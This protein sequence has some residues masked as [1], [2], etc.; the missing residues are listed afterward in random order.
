MKL[1]TL[2]IG[3]RLESLCSITSRA[4][5]SK[6]N[7]LSFEG[8]L[9]S[10]ISL[11][12]LWEIPCPISFSVAKL[13]LQSFKNCLIGGLYLSVCL[14]MTRR[15]VVVSYVELNTPISKRVAVELLPVVRDECIWYTITA[16]DILPKEPFDAF[17]RNI[18][19]GLYFCPF[20][21]IIDNHDCKSN[22][23][24]FLGVKVPLYL[25][26]IVRRAKVKKSINFFLLLIV[27]PPI[28]SKP[29]LSL[30]HSTISLVVEK[31]NRKL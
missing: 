28:A 29:I 8:S 31:L 30:S 25:P 9:R 6:D 15:Q 11:K 22:T 14:R 18:Y 10:L 24:H 19:Q 26:L 21:K 5:F 13:L 3:L 23:P 27:F 2:I 17:S 4:H 7:H 12:N 20:S 1:D 16:N